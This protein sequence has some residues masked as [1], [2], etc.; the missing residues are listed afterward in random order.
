MDEGDLGNPYALDD[1]R[2]GEINLAT[3]G[4]LYRFLLKVTE[5]RESRGKREESPAESKAVDDAMLYMLGDGPN[6]AERDIALRMMMEEIFDAPRRMEVAKRVLAHK[7]GIADEKEKE[8]EYELA[9]REHTPK[10]P[11]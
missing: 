4:R 9:G 8:F 6:K 10:C 7:Y 3:L 1:V 11:P 2:I 5:H